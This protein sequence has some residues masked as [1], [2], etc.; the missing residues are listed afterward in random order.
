MVV[1]SRFISKLGERGMLFYK[2]LYKADGFQWDDQAAAAFIKLKQYLKSL[3]TLISP[4]P[5]E[6]LLL[7]VVA[8]DA[9]VS[10]IIAIEQPGAATKVK[11]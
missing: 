6:I 10:T 1:L 9:V 2:L 7:Y 8:T 4:Q 3:P 11:Q 5:D